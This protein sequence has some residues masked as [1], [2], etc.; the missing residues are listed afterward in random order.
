MSK[1]NSASKIIAQNRKARHN[2]FITER[3]EAGIIL[4]GSE[5]KSLRH[6][7]SNIEDSYVTHDNEELY[8]LNM[9]ISEC[10]QA[11][12]F[13]HAPKRPRK[14]LVKKRQINKIIAA[15]RRQ[16]MTLVPLSLYFNEK[17]RAKVE[18]GLVEGKKKADKRATEK[19]R[20]WNRQKGRI[21]RARG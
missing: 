10:P 8:L 3:F 18:L 20:D 2:F 5:V 12:H 6:G 4:M 17:G 16:G 15:I 13:G 7:K 1:T 21:L 9:F 11:K 14:L 19:E